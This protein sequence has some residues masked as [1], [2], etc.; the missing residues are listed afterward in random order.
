MEK[1]TKLNTDTFEIETTI[2]KRL[3]LK[4][5]KAEL[6]QIKAINAEADKVEKWK[7]TTPRE[8][9]WCIN[10]PPRMDEEVILKQ[11]AELEAIK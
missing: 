3:S 8:F 7:S 6:E 10:V 11:I 5:L 1:I 2:K 4:D 9:H